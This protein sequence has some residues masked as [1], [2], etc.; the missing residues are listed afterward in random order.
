MGR[1]RKNPLPET[2]EPEIFDPNGEVV[3]DPG[4]T[5][6]EPNVEGDA[7]A[8]PRKRRSRSPGAKPVNFDV[9][10]VE[11]LLMSIHYSLSALTGVQE[12]Q[13]DATEA[14]N[15]SSAIGNVARHYDMPELPQQMIDWA[16]LAIV[17][18]VVYG[19]RVVAVR[20]RA[21]AQKKAALQ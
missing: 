1:P 15:L 16:N 3:L 19:P 13:L 4:A 12:L 5:M 8:E 18:A 21:S 9:K 7:K 6:A 10:G 11:A 20:A 17:A 2:N 14:K